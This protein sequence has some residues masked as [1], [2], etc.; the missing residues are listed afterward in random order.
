M[1]T[2][3]NLRKYSFRSCEL[4]RHVSHQLALYL[5]PRTCPTYSHQRQRKR[6]E[7]S[8][9]QPCNP[10]WPLPF[11]WS[12]TLNERYLLPMKK[13]LCSAASKPI[14][15][16]EQSLRSK[17][18]QMYKKFKKKLKTWLPGGR[19]DRG[20]CSESGR[21]PPRSSLPTV[22]KAVFQVRQCINSSDH[23]TSTWREGRDL[24]PRVWGC[25]VK[26]SKGYIAGQLTHD[27]PLVG[28]SLV[29]QN[30][31]ESTQ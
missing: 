27:L 9:T 1:V 31:P 28:T 14:P 15:K 8:P 22:G 26:K 19:T 12:L 11:A 20:P 6:P 3:L 18:G 16:I 10:C 17:S 30:Y 2:F 25:S 23:V 21:N 29:L 4:G 7:P 24:M 13:E 5:S